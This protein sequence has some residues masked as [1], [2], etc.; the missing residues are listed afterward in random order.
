MNVSIGTGDSGNGGSFYLKAG[1]TTAEET[2][3]GNITVIAGKGSDTS[4]ADGGNGGIIKFFGGEG[5]G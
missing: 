5:L 1:E 4:A 3:G 2:R